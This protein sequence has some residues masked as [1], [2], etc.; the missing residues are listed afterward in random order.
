MTTI[1][2]TLTF[3]SKVIFAIVQTKQLCQKIQEEFVLPA[4]KQARNS[5]IFLMEAI[6]I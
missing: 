1:Y 2:L 4:I 5:S 6:H 3:D